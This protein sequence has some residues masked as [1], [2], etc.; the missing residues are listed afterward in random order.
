MLQLPKDLLKGN[1]QYDLWTLRKDDSST[2]INV[3]QNTNERTC[4]YLC[5]VSLLICFCWSAVWVWS[6]IRGN[7]SMDSHYSCNFVK[8]CLQHKCFPVNFERTSILLN[9]CKQVFFWLYEHLWCNKVL[10]YPC[11]IKDM[12][13]PY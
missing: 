3:L 13:E 8:K 2:P 5:Y 9:I 10:P 1:A 4:D 12:V 6:V 11:S 7:T